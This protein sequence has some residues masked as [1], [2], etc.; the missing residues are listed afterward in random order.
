M[1]MW[2]YINFIIIS[3]IIIVIVIMIMCTNLVQ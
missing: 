2:H 3:I 1:I